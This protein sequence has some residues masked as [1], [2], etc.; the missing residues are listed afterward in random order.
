VT[1]ELYY[2]HPLAGVHVQKLCETCANGPDC[3]QVNRGLPA[4]VPARGGRMAD[5]R[6]CGRYLADTNQTEE[7]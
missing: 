1:H 3:V 4:A 2:T 5:G 6:P 7:D